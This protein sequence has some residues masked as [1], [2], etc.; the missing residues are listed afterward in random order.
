LPTAYDP[1]Q[2]F[3]FA[4]TDRTQLQYYS[5]AGTFNQSGKQSPES[6]QRLPFIQQSPGQGSYRG[7]RRGKYDVRKARR[8]S[9][10]NDDSNRYSNRNQYQYRSHPNNF[11]NARRFLLDPALE[12]NYRNYIRQNTY[13]S[14]LSQY[15]N[16]NNI[17]N[18][19]LSGNSYVG[20]ENRYGDSGNN[21]HGFQYNYP[22]STTLSNNPECYAPSAFVAQ[23][24]DMMPGFS[25]ETKIM[26]QT[27]MAASSTQEQRRQSFVP[28]PFAPT[29][30]PRFK[31]VH[32][33]HAK[34]AEVDAQYQVP[35][36]V[37]HF[38]MA[39]DAGASQYQLQGYGM[40]PFAPAPFIGAI[41]GPM[42]AEWMSQSP[43]PVLYEPPKPAVSMPP[44]GEFSPPKARKNGK[45]AKKI[46]QRAL[47]GT[48][49]NN[50]DA[51]DAATAFVG[52]H[53]ED[54]ANEMD[55][56]A[57]ELDDGDSEYMPQ[58]EGRRTKYSKPKKPK[59]KRGAGLA[60]CAKSELMAE[61]G[62]SAIDVR[63][64]MKAT[65]TVAATATNPTMAAHTTTATTMI[66]ATAAAESEA[67]VTAEEDEEMIEG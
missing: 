66:A 11:D 25:L 5:P 18:R 64:V 51:G 16:P 34:Q 24:Q 65:T 59:N 33:E 28:S 49:A 12:A 32:H 19:H 52:K 39:G 1:Q 31:D 4:Q 48:A 35:V 62:E 38:V 21:D 37:P 55:A 45:L 6:Q 15:S 61:D 47:V 40:L 22:A 2:Q 3:A 53:N 54:V 42:G 7:Q 29:F 63:D 13:N 30:T 41:P 50:V 57:D 46:L 58:N 67:Q 17:Q 20:Y 44:M 56:D 26:A 23:E 10:E 9:D 60:S 8:W 27:Q 36:Q 43:Q 14:G